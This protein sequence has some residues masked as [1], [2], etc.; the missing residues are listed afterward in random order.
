M[1]KLIDFVT[2]N[3]LGIVLVTTLL[4]LLFVVPSGGL[5]SLADL[6]WPTA[7]IIVGLIYRTPLSNLINRIKSMK[8]AGVSVGF[9]PHA[10]ADKVEGP[11]EREDG[12]DSLRESAK[13]VIAALWH[14]QGEPKEG[15]WTFAVFPPAPGWEKYID[16]V[17]E[18]SY[19][20]LVGVSPVS[21]QALLSDIGFAFCRSNSESLSK[22]ERL[23]F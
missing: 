12:W 3:K 22:A 14:Y 6:A 18:L 9:D 19:R 2:A 15:R 13:W 11:P 17:K 20:G 16:G 21:G 10:P 1:K 5:P 23:H 7:V 8:G 4:L